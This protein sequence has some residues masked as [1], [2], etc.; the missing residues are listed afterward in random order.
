MKHAYDK[1]KDFR[2]WRHR[3]N[4]L[5]RKLKKKV[6]DADVYDL[7]NPDLV[8]VEEIDQ[9]MEEMKNIHI[10]KM[11]DGIKDMKEKHEL[12]T[13]LRDKIV[14]S[15]SI[16]LDELQHLERE[17]KYHGILIPE[18][19]ILKEKLKFNNK[20][21]S[22]LEETMTLAQLEERVEDLKPNLENI[23]HKLLDHLKEKINHGK[24]T[25]KKAVGFLA[26][27]SYSIDELSQMASLIKE[28]DNN[29]LRFEEI[30]NLRSIISNFF[31]LT[32]VI[33]VLY[34]VTALDF[35]KLV[36]GNFFSFADR[37]LDD[38]TEEAMKEI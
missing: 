33:H 37:R 30:E 21:E 3:L 11:D 25:Q 23:D 38:L 34:N 16:K 7:E 1:K 26:Q 2:L 36:K 5:N 24:K 9:I 14:D 27:N 4:I 29:K 20:I 22:L 19:K 8:H 31:L 10:M 17:M 32:E 12:I 15:S 28:A 13:K 6:D 35:D 18:S